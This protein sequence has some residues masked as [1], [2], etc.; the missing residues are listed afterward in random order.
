[1]KSTDV[2]AGNGLSHCKFRNIR[3]EFSQKI[4]EMAMYS[5]DTFI[6][7]LDA[8][9]WNGQ[10]DIQMKPL[11]KMGENIR[12]CSY[13]GMSVKAGGERK[14]GMAIRYEHAFNNK[15]FKNYFEC[16]NIIGSVV[17]L[18]TSDSLSVITGN[19]TYDNTFIVNKASAYIKLDNEACG[20]VLAYNSVT[21]NSFS[22]QVKK[23]VYIKNAKNNL[24]DNNNYNY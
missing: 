4:V 3:A 1:V 14:V 2:I 5:H 19:E 9:W 22:G 6:T 8:V 24:V 21:G 13:T 10:N 17:E 11:I 12:D 7:G 23:I 15:I 20:S 18:T 16:D